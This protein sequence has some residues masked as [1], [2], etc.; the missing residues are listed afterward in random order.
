[1]YVAEGTYSEVNND[2]G[3]GQIAFINNDI[4]LI[5]GFD[6]ADWSEWSPHDN[7]TFLDPQGAGRAVYL[8]QQQCVGARF[9]DHKW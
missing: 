4:A 2:S 1:M 7:Y 5:G 6:S 3:L 8:N 9:R